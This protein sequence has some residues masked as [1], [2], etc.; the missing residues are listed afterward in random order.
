LTYV[1][2]GALAGSTTAYLTYALPGIIVMNMPFVAMYVGMGLNVDLTRGVFDRL[3]SLPIARWAPLAGRI[4]ADLVKQ[5]W[6]ITL[7]LGVGM[8]LGFRVGTNLAGLLAGMALILAYAFA[9]SWVSVLIGVLAKDPERVQIFSYT[10]MFPITFM[11]SVFVR[12]ETMPSW[13]Q[14]IVRANPISVLADA[15]RGLMVGGPVAGPVVVSLLWT[16]GTVAVF[17]PLSMWALKRRV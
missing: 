14:P 12:V 2:G 8:I 1:F 9:F 4:G 6:S 11:S 17:V 15:A 13:L 3:R 5:A 10:A 7:L 16:V